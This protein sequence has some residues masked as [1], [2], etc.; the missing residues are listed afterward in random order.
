MS[1]DGTSSG[2]ILPGVKGDQEQLIVYVELFPNLLISAHPDYVMTHMIQPLS[3]DRTRIACEWLFPPD[4]VADPGFDASYAV[5]FWD[6]T[7]QQDWAACEG[8]QRGLDS[9]GYRPG[10][11]SEVEE[12]LYR[13]LALVTHG[14]LNDGY[15]VD[16]WRR[17]VSQR[18]VTSPTG[19]Q[20]GA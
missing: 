17:I 13:H 16:W 8:V 18:A 5:D 19:S 1:L 7:N 12:D 14:Y 10:P 4:V 20:P 2:R 15:D 9:G 6:I 11:L 3:T